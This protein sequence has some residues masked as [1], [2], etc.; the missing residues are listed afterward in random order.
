MKFLYFALLKKRGPW[1][2]GILRK[3]RF[4]DIFENPESGPGGPSPLPEAIAPDPRPKIGLFHG[5]PKNPGVPP[6]PRGGEG[7]YP[8][9]GAQ[10][11]N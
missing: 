5:H 8:H 6:L 7:G 11:R 9:S 10:P 1:T 4:R 3:T 2:I